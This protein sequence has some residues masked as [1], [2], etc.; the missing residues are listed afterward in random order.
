MNKANIAYNLFCLFPSQQG[1]TPLKKAI[2]LNKADIARI[3]VANGASP[4]VRDPVSL[5]LEAAL[6]RLISKQ[7]YYK[8]HK[9]LF[10]SCQ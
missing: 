8:N 3:L 6:F 2:T 1:L 7:N 9:K 5:S 10:R 4:N